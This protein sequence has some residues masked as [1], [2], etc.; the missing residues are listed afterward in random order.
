MQT[1]L[2][3]I[4]ICPCWLNHSIVWSRQWE[5][6]SKRKCLTW[7][8]I[9]SS[10]WINQKA[11]WGLSY[12]MY[13]LLNDWIYVRVLYYCTDFSWARI[14]KHLVEAEKLTFRRELSFQR[15]GCTAGLTVATIF[16]VDCTDYFVKNQ[17]K[18][19]QFRWKDQH[20]YFILKISL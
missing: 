17:W 3:T 19:I 4:S 7:F 5:K 1:G 9:N 8:S 13:I 20:L 14:L 11:H 2:P 6:I 18:K 12:I 16:C 15:S 10:I